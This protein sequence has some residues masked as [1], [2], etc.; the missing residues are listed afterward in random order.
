VRI[1]AGTW[2]GRRIQAPKGRGVRPTTDRVREAWMSALQPRI[3]GARVVDLFAGSGALGLECLSRGAADAVFV[4]R[5]QASIGAI[6]ANIEALGAKDRT[7]VI[8][9]DAAAWAEKLGAGEFDLALADPPYDEGFLQRLLAA[10]Q[11]TPFA[12]EL[13]IEHRS[14]DLVPEGPSLRTRRY[15][16]TA[17]T[18]IE[19]PE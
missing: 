18:R 11:R 6:R 1:I 7:R 10:F 4:E 16:D 12:S 2:G 14:A 5:A 19:A 13:W 15:G 17:I 8:Q 3:P 9:A